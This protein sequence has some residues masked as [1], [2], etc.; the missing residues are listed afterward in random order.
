MIWGMSDSELVVDLAN[1]AKLK[2]V[3][4]ERANQ[5]HMSPQDGARAFSFNLKCPVK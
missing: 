4:V 1:L 2:G 5:A 3:W